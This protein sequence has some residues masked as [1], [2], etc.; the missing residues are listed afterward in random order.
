LGDLLDAERAVFGVDEHP[1]VAGLGDQHGR[2]GGAQVMH[3]E[4]ERHLAGCEALS[5]RADREGHRFHP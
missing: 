3:A 2:R 4:T 5:G 1:V